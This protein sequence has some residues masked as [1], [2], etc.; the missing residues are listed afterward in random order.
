[1]AILLRDVLA[2]DVLLGAV[3][4]TKFLGRVASALALGGFLTAAPMVPAHA[5]DE[6][7]KDWTLNW[8]IGATTDYVFRGVSQ[9][10]EK[11]TI[12]GGADFTYKMFYAGIFIASVE[13]APD[14]PG[15]GVGVVEIDYYAG[16]KFPVGKMV[17]VDL[18]GIFYSYPGANDSIATGFRE[19]DYFEFKAGAKFKPLD[20]LTF[21]A[22]VFYSPEGTNKTGEVW[23]F[24]GTAEYVFPKFGVVTPSI[25]ALIGY[26]TGD[27]A[28]FAAITANGADN[29]TY[30]NVGASAAVGDNLSFD[31]RY[32]DTDISDKGKFCTGAV[33]QCNERVVGT[34]KITF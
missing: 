20:A 16:V 21:G 17:E 22:F 24:E 25:S 30:W 18:G 8:N 6:P 14:N 23:T 5:A 2:R 27:D 32:W 15:P 12:Q 11:P 4:K 3:L 28:R 10:A 29:Y 7:K 34:V 1:M 26:Q 13:F 9:S 31:V 19:L 33:L